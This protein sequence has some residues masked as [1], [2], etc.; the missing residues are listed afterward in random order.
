MLK[1]SGTLTRG[2]SG[3]RASL[4]GKKVV[5]RRADYPI[6]ELEAAASKNVDE[7]GNYTGP[8]PELYE[9]ENQ[10]SCQWEE[11]T[12]FSI[13]DIAIT[14]FFF[15]LSFYVFRSLLLYVTDTS[16]AP[17]HRKLHN[18]YREYGS[19]PKIPEIE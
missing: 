8:F 5:F 12:N 17:T 10:L 11:K 16:T 6:Y 4:L 2:Y 9:T 7:N 19:N 1:S 18:V 14:I 13:K 15:F 3:S